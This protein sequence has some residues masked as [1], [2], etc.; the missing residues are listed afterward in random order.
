VAHNFLICKTKKEPGTKK[1]VVSP[2]GLRWHPHV[3]LLD[4]SN[5]KKR[6]KNTLFLVYPTKVWKMLPITVCI[7]PVALRKVPYYI[8][9]IKLAA[10]AAK[11][12]NRRTPNAS[13]KK[14]LFIK[15]KGLCSKCKLPLLDSDLSEVLHSNRIIDNIDGVQLHHKNPIAVGAKLSPEEHRKYDKID[16][17]ILL[18]TDCHKLTHI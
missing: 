1:E 2:Y 10:L 4:D 11:I 14:K 15:Q 7:L 12:M 5:N 3:K 13:Y 18:H 6:L 16:N 17:L 8:A 9:Y